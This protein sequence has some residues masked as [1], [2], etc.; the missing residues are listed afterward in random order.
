MTE[1]I[2]PFPNDRAA[3]VMRRFGQLSHDDQRATVTVVELIAVLHSFP[4]H[5]QIRALGLLQLF[6]C[7]SP[8]H[9]RILLELVEDGQF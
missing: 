7:L 8:D 6:S 9:Q 5:L 2:V 4:S 1:K 3:Q